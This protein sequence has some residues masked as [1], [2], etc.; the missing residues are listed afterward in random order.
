MGGVR[1]ATRTIFLEFKLT[2]DGLFIFIDP[3]VNALT[4][5]TGKLDEIILT[6]EVVT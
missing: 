3:I 4:V 1:L 5:L 2:R 6:H